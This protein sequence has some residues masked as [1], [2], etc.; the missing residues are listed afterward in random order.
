MAYAVIAGVPPQYGIYSSIIQGVFGALLSS[1]EHV[2]TGPT[3][4]QSLLIASAAMPLVD[5][6]FKPELYLQV[7]FMLTLLKG[8]IQLG[9]WSLH[10][11]ELVQFIS[12]SVL[13]GISAG[14]GVL[15]IVGQTGPMLGLNTAGTSGLPG[16]VGSIS[17]LTQNYNGLNW[18]SIGIALGVLG[19]AFIARRINRFMP[20][21]LIGVVAAG[22]LVAMMGWESRVAVIG[23]LPHTLPHLQVPGRGLSLKI[24]YDLLPGALA[25]ALLGGI[26]SVAIAKTIAARSGERIV[27]NQEFFAQGFKNALTSFVQC[28]P[29]SAS[30]T[31]SM[32][33]Y[34]SGA[35]T[36]YAAVMNALFVGVLFFAMSKFARY[37]PMAALAGV[38]IF[39]AFR[40]IDVAFLRRIARADRSDAAVLIITFLA[41]LFTRLEYA[42]F[43]GIFASIT[44]FLR[45]SSRLHV[46]EMEEIEPGK[47]IERAVYD[48]QGQRQIVFLQLEGDLFFAVADQLQEKLSDSR[49]DGVRA[50]ILRLKRC[51][52]IDGTALDVLDRFVID[53][54]RHNGH[55]LLCGVRDEVMKTLQNYGLVS[56]IG[57]DN[58]FVAERGVFVGARRAIDRA[59]KLIGVSIDSAAVNLSDEFAYDI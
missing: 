18:Y 27:A 52:S 2:T 58:I 13:V 21:P 26:E 56:L 51:H 40:L 44:F 36:R 34:E 46:A 53:M 42:I 10:A 20:G 23:I 29:G 57:R 32:L 3:N 55:V 5:P 48:R 50:I 4:T 12:R 49:R 14:A 1:S 17:R 38:L 28:M 6:H 31:R 15:I 54:H 39:I 16:I 24:V 47:F 35:E 59:R 30:F 7:V 22:L 9:L 33:D 45:T 41:V 11:G 43:I 25:L 37:I 19:L 8:C